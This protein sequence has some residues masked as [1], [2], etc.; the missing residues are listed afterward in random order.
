[1]AHQVQKNEV[2][3][4]CAYP[5]SQYVSDKN[6]S[7][8][9]SSLQLDGCMEKIWKCEQFLYKE[10]DNVRIRLAMVDRENAELELEIAM[11]D[12]QLEFTRMEQAKVIGSISAKLDALEK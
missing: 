1:M 12:S 9:T 7:P 10:V 6:L 2:L 4:L 11:A 8:S 3:S 5:C